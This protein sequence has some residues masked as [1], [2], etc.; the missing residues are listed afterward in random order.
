[1][2][3]VIEL[4][5]RLDGYLHR[6]EKMQLGRERKIVSG[7]PDA[8]C[9]EEKIIYPNLWIYDQPKAPKLEDEGRAIIDYRVENRSSTV[10]RGKPEKH[11]VD[12]KVIAIEPIRTSR[13]KKNFSSVRDRI[14]A[15]LTE[16]SDRQRDRAGRYVAGQSG[17]G[18]DDF[19]AAHG[20]KKKLL[21]SVAGVAA[22]AGAGG[23]VA[24]TGIGRRAASR[25]GAGAL[26]GIMKGE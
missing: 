16:F 13:K 23:I 19:R 26:R 11:S 18:I 20:K 1:M 25:L 2:G 15:I 17:A 22:L 6:F 21:R 14:D 5:S 8:S 24:S 10:K 12:M 3:S 7:C 9:G 4:S